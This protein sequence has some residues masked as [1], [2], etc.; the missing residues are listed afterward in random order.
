VSEPTHINIDVNLPALLGKLQVELQRLSDLTTIGLVGTP[1]VEEAD[2]R[3]PRDFA[4]LQIASDKRMS[5]SKARE[6]FQTWCLK[7]SFTEAIDLLSAFLEECRTIAA[8]FRLHG[9][10]T[11]SD[12]NKAYIEDAKKFHELGFPKKIE[13]LR[14]EFGIASKFEDH[15]LS[16]NRARNCLVHRLGIV[17]PKDVDSGGRLVV[18][19]HSLN[20]IAIDNSTGR[21]T[22]LV[23]PTVL[24]SES[25]IAA[26]VGPYQ[27]EFRV[28]DRILFDRNE[29][30]HTVF[31]FY[32]FALE[33]VQALAKLQPETSHDG[34]KLS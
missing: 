6:E 3:E 18:T 15:V 17:S 21:E 23:E 12:L 16:L 32:V 9:A 26:R 1:K 8:L 25:R 34:D 10:C 30:K 22:I 31:T 2:Y 4:A 27:R 29:H 24:E 20:L 7:N 14:N 33:I 19:W 11:G 28:G 5:L 13:H